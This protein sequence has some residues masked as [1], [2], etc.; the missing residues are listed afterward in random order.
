[1]HIP[2][3]MLNGAICPTTI[4]VAAGAVAVAAGLTAKAV[5]KPSVKKFA[6]VSTAIFVLQMLNFPVSSGTS[7][8]FMGAAFAVW[9]L[10]TA[11]AVLSMS[12]ILAVQALFFGDGGVIA[13][14]ANI[15]AMAVTG[16]VVSSAAIKLCSLISGKASRKASYSAAALVSLPTAAFSCSL[17]LWLAGLSSFARIASEMAL[18]HSVIGITEAVITFLLISLVTS[19]SA[20]DKKEPIFASMLALAAL[21]ASIASSLP[22]GLEHV[23]EKLGFSDAATPFFSAIFQDYSLSWIASPALNAIIA[24]LAGVVAIFVLSAAFSRTAAFIEKKW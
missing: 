8:H 9:A 15:M 5:E 2:D 1:M 10:G 18:V 21:T 22:D 20:S 24:S 12:L 3:G 11:P 16:V 19:I 17:M 7:G 14:G 6:A 4:A 13:L 23:A